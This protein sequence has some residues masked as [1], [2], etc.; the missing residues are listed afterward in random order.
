MI[1]YSKLIAY[2]FNKYYDDYFFG[3]KLLFKY[4]IML[5]STTKKDIIKSNNGEIV[6]NL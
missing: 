2:D 6:H 4:P 5:K 1:V 3:K